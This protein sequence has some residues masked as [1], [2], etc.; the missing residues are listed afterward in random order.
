MCPSSIDPAP[1][2]QRQREVGAVADDPDLLGLVEQRRDPRHPRRLG[3]PVAE[4][5]AVDELLV[6]IER[7]AGLLSGRVRREL[8]RPPTG[9]PSPS[10][11]GGAVPS[12]SAAAAGARRRA[13]SPRG[14]S[15]SAEIE[16]KASH[17][18]QARKMSGAGVPSSSSGPHV[19]T[20]RR[21][22]PTRARRS[23]ELLFARPA[24]APHP[25]AA[26]RE[27]SNGR[28]PASPP[29]HRRIG[30]R[31]GAQDRRSAGRAWRAS[32]TFVTA[33]SQPPESTGFDF[34]RNF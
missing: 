8:A 30:R 5:G 24:P 14:R 28:T 25:R 22:S 31:A 7:E 23:D 27:E 11:G 15:P 18:S 4:H 17:S 33:P 12:A 10:A 16:M 13:P 3:V 20:G 32:S 2:G 9:P 6:L 34:R 1:A 21:T 29:R 26:A 19:R